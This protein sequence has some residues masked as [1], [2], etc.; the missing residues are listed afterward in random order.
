M[1]QPLHVPVWTLEAADHGDRKFQ[2][3]Q[4]KAGP[5]TMNSFRAGLL[6]KVML[7]PKLSDQ[8]E[9]EHRARPPLGTSPSM[10][11]SPKQIPLP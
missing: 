6:E 4:T 10:M 2:A 1:N 5:L 8:E 3:M 11:L 7:K 9:L